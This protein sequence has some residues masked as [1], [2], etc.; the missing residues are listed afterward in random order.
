MKRIMQ[1]VTLMFLLAVS[2]SAATYYI[3][4]VGGSSANA[5]TSKAAPWKLAPGMP[6][7]AQPLY[8]HKPGDQFIFKG[9]VT[10]TKVALPLTIKYSGAAGATD[11]YGGEDQTWFTGPMWSQPVIDGQQLSG[12]NSYLIGD[13]GWHGRISF[14]KIDNFLVKN[15]GNKTDSSRTAISFGGGGNNIEISR[16]TLQPLS[17][18][19]IAYSNSYLPKGSLSSHI[20]IHD[21]KI[22]WGGRFIVYGYTGSVVDDVEVYGNEIQGAG[23]YNPAGYHQDG[24]MIGNPTSDCTRPTPPK[25]LNLNPTVTHI[26]FH[27]NWFKGLWPG[28]GTAQYFAN[29]CTNY[30]LIYNNVFSIEGPVPIALGY[31]IRFQ[32]HDG[33]ISIVNNTFSSDAAPGKDAGYSGAIVLAPS[34]QPHYGALVIENNISSGFGIDWSGL[35]PS[36]WSSVT[37][38]YNLHNLS[39]AHGYGDFAYFMNPT[40]TASTQC[41]TLAC[42]QKT[43]GYEMHSL[44]AVPMFTAIPNGTLGSGNFCLLPGSPAIG[45]GVNLSALFKTDAAGQPRPSTGPWDIGAFGVHGLTGGAAI[46]GGT[47]SPK[48]PGPLPGLAPKN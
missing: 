18:Q 43:W 2:A 19:S 5:G 9:G 37:I 46:M 17:V 1:A 8:V 44:A 7:F 3:D 32:S 29:S 16:C 10:W 41:K 4:F 15:S 47:T 42:V 20:L 13:G 27:D 22:M 45:K 11:V 33:N 36:N 25:V 28:G 31:A 6:G 34:Y 35:V 21:N 12:P 23:T 39:L 24:L 30:T 26:S 38:D 14:I 48:V 40:G